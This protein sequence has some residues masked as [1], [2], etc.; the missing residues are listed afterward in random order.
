[1]AALVSLEGATGILS[2][3][4]SSSSSLSSF[5]SSFSSFSGSLLS[6][7]SSAVSPSLL[8]ASGAGGG[9]CI[10]LLASGSLL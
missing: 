7:S 4:L 3:S 10:A 9:L 8:R 1:M 2:R 5:S 6:S